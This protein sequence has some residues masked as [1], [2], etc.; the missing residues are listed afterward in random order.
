MHI[1]NKKFGLKT[2]WYE[3]TKLVER[4][5]QATRSK[6]TAKVAKIRSK[7]PICSRLLKLL[8]VSAIREPTSADVGES[9]D[10]GDWSG[11]KC[12]GG[13]VVGGGW[14]GEWWWWREQN[15]F[16][17]SGTNSILYVIFHTMS[18]S[19]KTLGRLYAVSV[20]KTLSVSVQ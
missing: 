10:G 8:K 5:K 15:K 6:N 18:Y 11:G 9:W 1:K 4:I 12:V 2:Y 7:S 3:T 20:E 17:I 16:Q 19:N 14:W 13:K